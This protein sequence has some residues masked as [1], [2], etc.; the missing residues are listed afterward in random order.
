[1]NYNNLEKLKNFVK[2]DVIL[3]YKDKEKKIYQ[4]RRNRIKN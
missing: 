3:I 4:K 1:M 2:S